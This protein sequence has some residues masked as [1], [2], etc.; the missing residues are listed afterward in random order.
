[1]STRQSVGLFLAATFAW[2]WLLWGYWVFAMPPGGLQISPAFVVCAIVGGLAPS[3][4]AIAVS[5]ADRGTAVADLLRPLAFT[6]FPAP[7]YLT[8]LLLVPLTALISA[9]LQAQLIG[10]L[11]WPDPALLG[12]AL[13][14]PVLAALGEEIGWRGYL[15]P[16]LDQRYG[17]LPAA[18]LVGIVWGIWHLP[19][20]YVA[21]KGYGDWFGVAFLLNGPVILTAH[22]VIL[23][24][25]WRRTQGSLLVA[26]LYH[27]S[28]TASAI[29]APSASADGLPGIYAAAIGA[30]LMWLVA[31]AL[32][33]LRRNDFRQAAVGAKVSDTPF[34]Q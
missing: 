7:L 22:S 16:R 21:L 26:V 34:M 1:M 10:P 31:G 8:A 9:A 20:D 14:W 17:L 30:A 11:R 12:M 2:A 4:A 13:V 28:I 3:L 19:A 15:L 27:W 32:I 23:A 29:A 5:A 24:W 18:I 25:L 6:Q 33:A